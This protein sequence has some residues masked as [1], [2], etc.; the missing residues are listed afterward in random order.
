MTVSSHLRQTV[1]ERFQ[2]SRFVSCDMFRGFVAGLDEL[3]T[4]LFIKTA[5]QCQR[6]SWRRSSGLLMPQVCFELS[7][8]GKTE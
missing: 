4:V 8:V 3:F 1:T 6:E 5:E 2:F 7:G